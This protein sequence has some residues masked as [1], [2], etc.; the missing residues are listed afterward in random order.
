VRNLALIFI[1]LI[2]VPLSLFAQP[3]ITTPPTNQVVAV[4]G[5]LTLSVTAT[6]SGPL[7]YQWFKDNRQLPGA[8]SS[9]L[10]ILNAGMTNSGNYYVVV[11]NAGGMA[12]SLPAWARV[13]SPILLGWGNNS[14]GQ[15]G[16]GSTSDAQTNLIPIATNVVAGAVGGYHSLY[17]TMDGTL[18]AMGWNYYGQL[19]NGTNADSYLP[20]IVASNVVTVAAGFAHSLFVTKDKTLWAVGWNQHG[21]LGN[22]QSFLTSFFSTNVPISVASNVVAVSAGLAHSLFIKADGTLWAMG[23]GGNGEIGNGT[24]NDAPLPVCVATNV[25]AIGAGDIFSMLITADDR[26]SMM[27]WN[28]DGQLGNGTT[29]GFGFDTNTPSIMASNVV[30]IA[31]G[32]QH[33]L[34]LSGNGVL[35]GAGFNGYGQLG[36]G[37]TSDTNRPVNIATNVV[38]MAAGYWHT[39]FVKGDGRLWATGN[40][41]YG[42][43]GDGTITDTHL[44]VN[45]PHLW[46]ADI[47][48]GDES[49]HS[50]VIGNTQSLAQV[51]LGNLNPTYTGSSINVTSNTTPPG[52]RVDITYNGSPNPATNAGPY[53]VVGTIQDFNYYGAVTNTLVV[54]KAQ[55]GV[56]L[57]GLSQTFTGVGISVTPAT[58]PAGLTVIVTYNGSSTP[59]TDSGSYT[60]VGAVNDLNY[61]GAVTN[62]LTIS[63]APA[64]VILSN[65]FQPYTGG[66]I[67]ISSSTMPP[68]LAVNLQYNGSQSPPTNAGS[69]SVVGTINDRNYFGS[70]T[71]VLIIGLP[72]Q[73][74]VARSTNINGDH[75]MALQ[76][77]G[78]PNY[79]Y[80]LQMATNLSAPATWQSIF[81]NPA[82]AGGNWTCIISNLASPPRAFLRAAAR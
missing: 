27:G 78:T 39:L 51:T 44:P 8:T 54:K 71:N 77:S 65:L 64:V 49:Y 70:A 6:G 81:T 34:R 4:G 38:G 42:Q 66:P 52:L 15:L 21:Q 22:G 7:F 80:I 33:S 74:F 14:N 69:Y 46:V 43:L 47:L 19:G 76:L 57:G 1:I 30:A 72:P 10:T 12:I 36:N 73:N 79:P 26:L 68:S 67:L 56:A 45:V 28:G 50:L 58:T 23:N 82:D 13:G 53:I 2:G 60:V 40:N 20:I 48:P 32:Y 11:T 31:A 75:Q 63:Q 24:Y 18:W 41:S 16:N 17:I 5:T 35:S 62:T 59:P 37:T 55:A 3:I 29:T 9:T 61:F 25:V